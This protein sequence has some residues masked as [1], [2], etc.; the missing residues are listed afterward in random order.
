MSSRIDRLRHSWAILPATMALW[1]KKKVAIPECAT[2][3][4]EG[5]VLVCTNEQ[6]RT[7]FIHGSRGDYGV[8]IGEMILCHHDQ[9][10]TSKGHYT[11]QN[12]V[13]WTKVGSGVVID[14]VLGF[15]RNTKASLAVLK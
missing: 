11:I 10:G 7:C 5:T 9:T 4:D 8:K 12:I 15:D 6:G 1:G 3:W 13:T 2:V 14:S